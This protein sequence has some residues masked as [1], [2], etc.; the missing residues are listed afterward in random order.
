MSLF[1]V[2]TFHHLPLRMAWQPNPLVSVQKYIQTGLKGQKYIQTGLKGQRAK[3]SFPSILPN[4]RKKDKSRGDDYNL[5]KSKL[6]R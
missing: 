1:A 4:N 3:L 2:K 6:A 5:G